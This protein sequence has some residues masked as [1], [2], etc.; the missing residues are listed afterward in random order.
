[1]AYG[2]T[3]I[4]HLSNGKTVFIA[5]GV[6]GDVVELEITQ[7][8]P[9][10]A[11]AQISKILQKSP[12]RVTKLPKGAHANLSP[13]A[14]L[15]YEAQLAEKAACVASALQRTGGVAE[16]RLAEIMQ[17]IVPCKKQWG[18]RNKLEF[19]AYT[20]AAGRF[21]LGL[22]EQGSADELFEVNE[23]ALGNKFLQKA[24]H[25]LTGALRYLIGEGDTAAQL[26]IFR[27]GVRASEATKSVEVALWTPPSAFPRNF[28][29]K[30]LKDAV[31][32]TSIVR[33]LAQEGAARRVK[34]VEVLEGKGFWEERMQVLGNAYNYW[35]S[36]PSFFQV[37]TNQAAKLVELA[38][39]GLEAAPGTYVADL[40]CG[41]GTFT[42]PLAQAGCDVVAVEL[43]GS[44]A[45]DLKRN[46][47]NAGLDIDIIC[48]DVMRV[49]PELGQLDACV[50][51]PPR[52]G[53]EKQVVAQICAARPQKIA[54]ISCD[55]QT[56]ARDVA[57]FEARG[58]RLERA[59]PVDMFPQTYHVET[60]GILHVC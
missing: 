36:A 53:L 13:W 46:A 41:A 15:S 54:Y 5:G 18:Y 59:T 21:T 14:A 4:G 51:D 28:A 17:P 25:A 38:L 55:P 60:V 48:D 27:V 1:M 40:Y 34:R 6:P 11:Q 35:L 58:W 44:S 49:L 31:G 42:L 10:F 7:E 29:A 3:A 57:R 33:V 50:I 23:C 22:H 39:E 43:A 2:P 20:N 45:R 24:P 26:G 37:N 56:F 30:A 12:S 47:P 16:A 19:A 32:A 52:S 9:R 8:K